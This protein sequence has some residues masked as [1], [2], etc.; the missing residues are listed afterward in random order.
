MT[1]S[2]PKVFSPILLEQ[3]LCSTLSRGRRIA[4]RDVSPVAELF[5]CTWTFA[6]VNMVTGHCGTLSRAFPLSHGKPTR[7]LRGS[8][9]TP[10]SK[11]GDF[12]TEK[13][14]IIAG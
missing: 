6:K 2:G 11:E 13:I 14:T 5:P 3:S 10:A 9:Q 1:Q 7:G 8:C 4:T 12:L